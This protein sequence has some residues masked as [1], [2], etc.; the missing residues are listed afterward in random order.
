MSQRSDDERARLEAK[1]PVVKNAAIKGVGCGVLVFGGLAIATF[2]I[3]SLSPLA[4]IGVAYSAVGAIPWLIG[5]G[6]LLLV[7]RLLTRRK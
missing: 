1:H 6:A 4:P 2:I 3:W 5:A 7:V